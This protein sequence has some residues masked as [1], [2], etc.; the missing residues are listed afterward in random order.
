MQLYRCSSLGLELV[1]SF[2]ENENTRKSTTENIVLEFL[3]KKKFLEASK[4]V[5]NFE[6]TQVF[7]RGIGIDWKNY[8]NNSTVALLELIFESKP[9]ILRGVSNSQFEQLR[10]SAAMMHLWGVNTVKKWFSM[11][12]QTGTH[13]N[14]DAASRMILFHASHLSNMKEY[15]LNEVK[16][17]EIIGTEDNR[18]C[19]ECKKISKKK[20][21]LENTPELPYAKCTCLDGCR[22]LAL[23]IIDYE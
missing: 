16:T 15:L 22:C 19:A 9:A 1:D 7:A 8:S 12:F 21:R 17:V 10:I 23:P 18:N 5:A 13:L 6:A 11:D 14:I 3:K 4:T 2:L 20:Y